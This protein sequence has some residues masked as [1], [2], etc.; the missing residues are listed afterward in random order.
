MGRFFRRLSKHQDARYLVKL[1]EDSRR[2]LSY[3]DI[4]R[5]TSIYCD[6][7]ENNGNGRQLN[8]NMKQ[9]KDN[10]KNTM[11]LSEK[12]GLLHK[13]GWGTEFGKEYLKYEIYDK[14]LWNS[15]QKNRQNYSSPRNSNLVIQT[16][17]QLF[18]SF[19]SILWLKLVKFPLILTFQI[20]ENFGANNGEASTD[21]TGIEIL[22]AHP[23]SSWTK[24]ML[25]QT[26]L[27]S[28]IRTCFLP[29]K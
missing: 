29:C 2:F 10:F 5:I 18:P 11:A 6:Y 20:H 21:T 8:R 4:P 13:V 17:T 3:V 22:N 26:L 25:G 9:R 16:F 19:Q 14:G 12:N 24:L 1:E 23:A 15:L 7:K 27:F 28:V